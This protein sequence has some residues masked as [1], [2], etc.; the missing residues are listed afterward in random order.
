MNNASSQHRPSFQGFFQALTVISALCSLHTLAG[1]A[2]LAAD[3]TNSSPAAHLRG[4]AQVDGEGIFLTQV[5]Q[6][7]GGEVPRLRL[8]DSPAYGK[9]VLL[10][11]GEIAEFARQAGLEQALTNWAGPEVVRV[12]RLVRPLAEKEVLQL[13]TASL[14]Q[15]YVKELGELELRLS[16]PWLT[17]NVPDEPFTIEIQDLPTIGVTPSFIARFEIQTS[18]GERIG[19]WQASLQAKVWR[20]VWVTR[21]LV[22]RGQP[23]QGADLV[24]DRRDMLLCREPLAELAADESSFEFVEPIQAGTP[25]LARLIRP[26]AIVHRGQSLA[27]MVQDGTLS[28]TL[29]VEALEDGALGQS[30]RVR[31]PLSRRDLHAKVVDE[32]NVLVSL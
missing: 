25:V 26:H 6:P 20:E 27:A 8:C 22:K 19:S 9:S 32:Q 30:I 23:V 4:V 28:I 13:L 29:K 12:S 17:I 21:S 16:R 11:R 1:E 10:K 3:F 7:S 31:N 15:H 2:P 5:L 14:Q 18:H 24:R